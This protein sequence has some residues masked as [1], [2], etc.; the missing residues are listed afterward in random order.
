MPIEKLQPYRPV[1]HIIDDDESVGNALTDLLRAA[2]ISAKSFSSPKGFIEAW[3]PTD[4]GCVLLDLWFPD[5][6]GL[7][8]QSQLLD[9]E[10]TLPVILMTGHADVPSSI[11]GMK[12]GAIDF[13]VKPFD[14]HMVLESIQTAFKRDEARVNDE[15]RI[16]LLSDRYTTL[17]TREKEV[18]SL[19]TKGLMNKQIAGELN[20]SE[21]T[22]K[23]HRGTM[24]RKMHV[25]TVADLVRASELLRA[26]PVQARV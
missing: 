19:V 22:V 17:T 9:L 1:V 26:N 13:L 8:F 24:M 16:L 12:A 25:R 5:E 11:R 18:F 23:V 14:D 15:A 2:G 20:L 6:S 4:H 10:M 3:Q 7:D 21:I